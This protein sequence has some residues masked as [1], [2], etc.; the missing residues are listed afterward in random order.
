[1]I[2]YWEAIGRLA[3]DEDLFSKFQ[4]VLPSPENIQWETV[5][6]TAIKA[7]STCLNIPERQYK[8]VQ[9]FLSPILTEQYLSL[10]AAGELIWTFN[11][12]KSR[13]SFCRMQPAILAAEPRLPCPSASYFIALGLVIVDGL[14]RK[15][16]ERR[17]RKAPGTSEAL[18]D[19][20]PR[21]SDPQRDQI[22]NLVKCP[23]FQEFAE[24]FDS[25]PWEQ[26]C[27]V[28]ESTRAEYRH[29][30]ALDAK[31]DQ[32]GAPPA[33]TLWAAIPS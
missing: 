4:K 24:M 16:A 31:E 15:E 3:Y 30:I 21:L 6:A 29:P 14:F 32:A 13:E 1:M 28:A 33:E 9:A 17:T 8:A 5:T 12:E 19:L 10:F 23:R 18:R 27:F 25:D 2:D 20:L 22:M 11:T 26:G 7:S